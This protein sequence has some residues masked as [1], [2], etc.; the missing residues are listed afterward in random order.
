MLGPRSSTMAAPRSPRSPRSSVFTLESAGHPSHVLR[1]LDEQRRRDALCDVTVAVEGRAFRAH[2]AVLAACSAYFAQ[3]IP[4]LTQQPGAVISLPPEVTAAGFEPLLSFC[5]TSKLHLDRDNVLEVRA[6]ASVLGVPD[7]DEACFHFLLPKFLSP[8]EGGPPS[9]RKTCC[10][11]GCRRRPLKESCGGPAADPAP[12]QEV[13][14][15][16][17]RPV[18]GAAEPTP[19]PAEVPGGTD[20]RFLQCPKYR[21]FQ[22]ACGK[23]TPAPPCSPG[24]GS[25]ASSGPSASVTFPDADAAET[26]ASDRTGLCN[27]LG[28]RDPQVKQDPLPLGVLDPQAVQDPPGVLDGDPAVHRSLQHE[29]LNIDLT[30][31]PGPGESGSPHQGGDEGPGNEISAQD[32][33]KGE[34]TGSRG[35]LGPDEGPSYLSTRDPGDPGGLRTAVGGAGCLDWHKIH[36]NLGFSSGARCPFFRDLDCPWRGAPVG[37]GALEGEGAPEGEGGPQSG[38]SSLNSGEDGDSGT[39]TEGDSESSARERARQVRL[40]FPVDWIVTLSRNDFQTLLKQHDF[41]QEQLDFVH[42]MR[43]RSKNR[44]AARR[45]RKRK[46][47]CIYNLQCEINKLKT[48]RETLMLERRQLGQLKLKTCHSVT[49]LCQRV[50]SE[51]Q[52]QPEQLQVLARYSSTDCPLSSLLPRGDAPP[53]PAQ[54]PGVPPGSY[55]GS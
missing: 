18:N 27:D 51:A 34:P 25:V 32:R 6:A 46:L 26:G 15:D 50:C 31:D 8:G 29:A 30:G 38:V 54:T 52:L 21:K 20:P 14:L 55:R 36:Q 49:T 13:P 44:L 33:G 3:R 24:P 37:E 45:C 47:D 19:A 7:L 42:D 22:L 28:V 40:P 41:T 43:R 12:R 53:V 17:H 23:E 5:Y 1:G 35:G 9:G 48:E 39:D 4:P 10:Q 2:R 16:P 11:S